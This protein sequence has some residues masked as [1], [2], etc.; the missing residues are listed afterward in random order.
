MQK[1]WCFKVKS[2]KVKGLEWKTR[3]PSVAKQLTVSAFPICR[4][5][6]SKRRLFTMQKAVF[7]TL[8]G[9][10]LHR[11]LPPFEVIR[12]LFG[13]YKNIYSWVYLSCL[14]LHP[15][16]IQAVGNCHSALRRGIQ[17][18]SRTPNDI[19]CIH[20]IPRRSAEWQL[21]TAWIATEYVHKM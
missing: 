1:G 15:D 3:W 20:W 10:L 11:D 17:K 12:S 6:P 7:Y 19:G 16:I 9:R 2:R 5:L 14:W 4:V 13:W 8:K 21:P 18:T